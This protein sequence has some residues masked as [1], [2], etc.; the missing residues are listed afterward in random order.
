M[1]LQEQISHMQQEL[2]KQIP[3]ETLETLM[4]AKAQMISEKPE[5]NALKEGDEIP[6]FSLYRQDGDLF[7]VRDVLQEKNLVISFF[8]G[9]WCPYCDIELHS[10][11]EH[12]PAIKMAGAELLAISPELTDQSMS[13]FEKQPIPFHVLSDSGNLVAK[14]FGIV[15]HLSEAFQQV[16]KGF[17]FNLVQKNGD[18]N[19][20]LPIPAT[21]LVTRDG[22]IQYAHINPDYSQRMEPA[23]IVRELQLLK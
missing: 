23:D 9:T 5:N 8:Q 21:Y 3:S 11:V 17:D 13:Y 20:K 6:S 12:Y 4:V 1:S 15:I 10:L 19:W 22:I 16:Y 7:G 14:K 18:L 2:V